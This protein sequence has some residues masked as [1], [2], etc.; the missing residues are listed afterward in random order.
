MLKQ[1]FDEDTGN[2]KSVVINLD[3][4]STLP[5]SS[6]FLTCGGGDFFLV[7]LSFQTWAPTKEP[8]TSPRLAQI[9]SLMLI[10]LSSQS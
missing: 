8:R 6:F 10:V 3:L 2:Q 7:L 1:A 5:G 9:M 4:C